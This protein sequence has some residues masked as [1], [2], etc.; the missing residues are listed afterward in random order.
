ME[1][2]NQS[3]WTG[4]AVLVVIVAVYF[5]LMPLN[6]NLKDLRLQVAAKRQEANDLDT[7]VSN[8]KKLQSQFASKSQDIERLKLALPSNVKADEI[9]IMLDSLATDSQLTLESIQ[10]EQVSVNQAQASSD[11]VNVTATV[12]GN[13]SGMTAFTEGLKN[14]I[15]PVTIKNVSLVTAGTEG[16]SSQLTGTFTLGF[17]VAK[18]APAT[19]A[20][21][22][23][24]EVK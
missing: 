14:N 11:T 1:N 18:A 9:F 10:P 19:P 3:T 4:L 8:L 7:K 15:R 12:S 13:F 2:T 21:A 22:T 20:T 16:D 5:G 6:R 23:G 17:L 24:Q